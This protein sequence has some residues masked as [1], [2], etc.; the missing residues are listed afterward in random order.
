MGRIDA[1]RR[2]VDGAR[3]TI[4]VGHER[5]ALHHPGLAGWAP[6]EVSSAAFAEGAVIP[7]HFAGDGDDVSPPLSWSKV[8]AATREVVVLCEDPDA[9]FPSPF[10]HWLIHGLPPAVRSLSEGVTDTPVIPAAHQGKNSRRD[11]GYMGPLP[12]PGH[13]VHHYY[14]EVFALD[15][16]L[17]LDGAPTRDQLVR[18]MR[19]HVIG[20]GALVGTY[21]RE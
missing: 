6:I 7:R 10:V 8:P 4:R 5:V 20:S 14:F 13:G 21:T 18:A 12:P 2:E 1:E 16:A 3:R 15:A 19:G 9:P 11:T 17:D